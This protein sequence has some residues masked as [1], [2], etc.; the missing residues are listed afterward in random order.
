[1]TKKL[2]FLVLLIGMSN[3]YA[4]SINAKKLLDEVATKVK[5][6]SNSSIKFNYT[7]TNVK[8][9]INQNS[10]GT[11]VLK[12]NQYVLN[13]FG[14]TKIY[15]GKKSYTINPEDEEVTISTVTE[16][17]EDQI[18]PSKMLNFFST[19][20]SYKT[21]VQKTIQGKKI[22]F[23]K[24]ISKSNTDAKKHII[25]GI[26]MQTKQ[27]YNVVDTDKKG[28]IITY[29]ITSFKTNQVLPK[30][31]FVFTP[32]KYPNYYINKLD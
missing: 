25:I 30:N 28:T 16:K 29:T 12:G 7:L 3:T 8:E 20:Y 26:D 19:G 22:Q 24:L 11:V 23:I 6:N 9:K 10:Q 17:N 5:S 27:I 32:S 1:M 18:S 15:D 21:D 2:F 14:I 13:I 4:Q 31:Q